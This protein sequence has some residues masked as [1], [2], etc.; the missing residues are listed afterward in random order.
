LNNTKNAVVVLVI[1]VLLSV[2]ISYLIAPTKQGEQG[3]QVLR[4]YR[5]LKESR[6]F[7]AHLDLS[8]HKEKEDQKVPYY[9]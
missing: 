1:S 6:A 7:E 8:D 4:G 9:L 5:G 3:L 2:T